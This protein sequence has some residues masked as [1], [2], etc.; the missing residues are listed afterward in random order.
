ME[1]SLIS[2]NIVDGTL[3]RKV[4]L[5]GCYIVRAKMA[6]YVISRDSQLLALNFKDKFV[7]PSAV[8]NDNHA[9]G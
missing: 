7:I 5:D 9:L 4:C 3:Q 1:G 6:C 2:N 8:H